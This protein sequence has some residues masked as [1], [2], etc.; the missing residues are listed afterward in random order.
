MS[1]NATT[2]SFPKVTFI[3]PYWGIKEFFG[4]TFYRDVGDN[5][6]IEILT[7]KFRN[8]LNIKGTIIPTS[9]GRT[10]FEL[11]L[12]VLKNKYPERNKVVIPTYGC[13]GTFDPIIKTG[14]TPVLVDVGKDLNITPSTAKD[15]LT[16]EVLAV[17]VPH[18][19]GC[20]AEIENLAK[21]AKEKNIIIIEDVCQALGGRN[22]TGFWGTQYDMAIFSFGMGKNLMATAGGFLVSNVFEKEIPDEAK[23]LGD[24]NTDTVKKRFENVVSKYFLKKDIEFE[25]RNI[26]SSYK[27]NKMHPLDAKLLLIQINR[28]ENI[29]QKRRSNAEKIIK[30]LKKTGLKFNLQEDMNNV[31]TKLSLIFEDANECSE[32]KSCFHKMGIEPEEMY[33]PLH[34]SN[35]GLKSSCPYS[36]KV[37]KN[38]FNIPIRP[39]LKNKELNMILKA[40]LNVKGSNGLKPS[41]KQTGGQARL[42]KIFTRLKRKTKKKKH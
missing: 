40:I 41:S 12:R 5:N 36:E 8:K 17:L 35:A 16:T 25:T 24:E 19:S 3:K 27:Y 20:K 31:Y 18:L 32:L 23:N 21:M 34:L 28:L 33:A 9:S 13:K 11:A 26:M 22:S 37:Y 7:K 2:P 6:S 42:H 38:V 30:E 4:G 15:Y 14:L 39:N 1:S 10:A 29:L